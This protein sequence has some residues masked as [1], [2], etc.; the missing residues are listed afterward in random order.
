MLKAD[1]ANRIK[2]K[3]FSNSISISFS[4]FTFLISKINNMYNSH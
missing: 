4:S 1:V 2:S 3:M